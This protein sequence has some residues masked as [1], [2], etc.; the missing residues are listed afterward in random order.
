MSAVGAVATKKDL[1]QDV[2]S[3]VPLIAS[4]IEETLSIRNTHS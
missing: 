2:V 3:G 1:S 4:V